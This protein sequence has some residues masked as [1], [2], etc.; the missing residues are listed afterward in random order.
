[1]AES[2]LRG[3]RISRRVFLKG[4]AAAGGLLALGP[5]S[6]CDGV[7]PDDMPS[8]PLRIG[9]V[10]TW[11]AWGSL[12]IAERKGFFKQY[13]ADV[14]IKS[15]A[16]SGALDALSTKKL[17]AAFLV[18]S[19]V[20]PMAAAGLP[21]QVVWAVD[22]VLTSDA[23][24]VRAGVN[25]LGD[26]RG[27]RIGVLY[28]GFSHFWVLKALEA[29]GIAPDEVSFMDVA[30]EDVPARLRSGE[31]DAGETWEPH[32]SEAVEDDGQA[33]LFPAN[34]P[35]PMIEGLVFQ[36]APIEKR[37][38]DVQAAVRGLMAAQQWWR[39]N[40][41]EGN[42]VV[43][44]GMN[45][46]VGEGD[47][48][49]TSVDIERTIAG[50]WLYRVEDNERVFARSD[51]AG[52]LYTVLAAVNDFFMRLGIVEESPA[53]DGVLNATFMREAAAS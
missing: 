49:V 13:G 8:S 42:A 38:A 35:V 22:Q 45:A 23:L 5:L 48:E 15:Y 36:R 16:Y 37:P 27:G 50:L 51:H 47:A 20:V 52:S 9:T 7:E 46:F 43:A 6:A 30:G 12:Y 25:E 29:K 24:V 28:G 34:S 4:A 31:I 26:L 33:L 2:V 17:D 21:V 53:L 3:R 32:I 44:D 1:M 41:I 14:E 10:S 40:P 19:D 11:A 18:V 39:R